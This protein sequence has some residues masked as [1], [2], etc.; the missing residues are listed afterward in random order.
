MRASLLFFALLLAFAAQ[1][2]VLLG[3]AH[4]PN[5]NLR[6][7][8]YTEGVHTHVVAYHENGRVQETRS[9]RNGKLDGLVKQFAETGALLTRATFQE[10]VRQGVW[11]F[12]TSSDQPLGALRFSNGTLTH[13]EQFDPTGEL[14]AQR[15]YR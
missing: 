8:V 5:G 14:I 3:Q 13:G 2:Q 10:G 7:T 11:E 1:A 9:Y 4:W 15:D 6:S 12:R